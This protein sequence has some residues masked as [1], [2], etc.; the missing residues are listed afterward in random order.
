MPAVVQSGPVPV[1][2]FVRAELVETFEVE[3]RGFIPDFDECFQAG[4]AGLRCA[5]RHGGYRRGARSSEL[6]LE[7]SREDF[8]LAFYDRSSE[9][10]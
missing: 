9:V 4:V 7:S 8:R 2:H 10:C 5:G 6:Q 1:A 3:V